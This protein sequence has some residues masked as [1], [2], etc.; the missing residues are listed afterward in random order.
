VRTAPFIEADFD[1]AATTYRM[2]N[3]ANPGSVSTSRGGVLLYVFGS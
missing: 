1:T 3:S 2:S